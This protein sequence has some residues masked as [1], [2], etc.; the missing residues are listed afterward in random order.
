MFRRFCYFLIVLLTLMGVFAF[1]LVDGVVAEKELMGLFAEGGLLTIDFENGDWREWL[2]VWDEGTQSNVVDSKVAEGVLHLDDAKQAVLNFPIE[3]GMLVHYHFRVSGLPEEAGTLVMAEMMNRRGGVGL[4]GQ[5]LG[6]G[7]FRVFEEGKTLME[8]GLWGDEFV[9]GEEW[10]D[11]FFWLDPNGMRM[12]MWTFDP[13]N[14]DVI[15]G[16]SFELPNDWQGETWGLNFAR[17]YFMWEGTPYL[18]EIEIL[19]D[20]VV[21]SGMAPRDYLVSI[22]AGQVP[23]GEFLS[24]PAMAFGENDEGDK[25]TTEREGM[26]FPETAMPMQEY[27]IDEDDF[28][29]VPFDE[30]MSEPVYMLDLVFK[31][32]KKLFEEGAD[33]MRNNQGG[34]FG[35]VA[36]KRFVNEDEFLF[37][38]TYEPAFVALNKTLTDFYTLNSVKGRAIYLNFKASEVEELRFALV[39]ND[40]VEFGISFEE[41]MIPRLFVVGEEEVYPLMFGEEEPPTL[42]MEEWYHFVLG[43]D[44]MGHCRG[45]FWPMDDFL[46]DG[47]FLDWDLTAFENGERFLNQPWEFVMEFDEMS[48]VTLKEY[49][50]YAFENYAA[51]KEDEAFLHEDFVPNEGT[52]LAEMGIAPA[53]F[54]DELEKNEDGSFSV[55][56]FDSGEDANDDTPAFVWRIHPEVNDVIRSVVVTFDLFEV[57]RPTNRFGAVGYHENDNSIGFVGYERGFLMGLYNFDGMTKNVIAE[58]RSYQDHFGRLPHGGVQLDVEEIVAMFAE[59][60]EDEDR[61]WSIEEMLQLPSA[62][63]MNLNEYVERVGATVQIEIP[64]G[65]FSRY[66]P[67]LTL[68]FL[69]GARF[70]NLQ[71][72]LVVEDDFEGDDAALVEAV[73]AP[74]EVNEDLWICGEIVT[75]NDCQP[76]VSGLEAEIND[77]APWTNLFFDERVFDGANLAEKVM[78][79]DVD[80]GKTFRMPVA[81]FDLGELEDDV[82]G[83]FVLVPEALPRLLTVSRWYEAPGDG[84]LSDLHQNTLRFVFEMMRDEETGLI[85]GIWDFGSNQ[86]VAEE[87]TYANLPLLFFLQPVLSEE[88]FLAYAEAIFVNEFFEWQGRYYYAPG[89][90]TMEDGKAQFVLALDDFDFE[91][92]RF[93]DF[94][95]DVSLFDFFDLKMAADFYEGIGR[96]FGFYLNQMEDVKTHLPAERIEVWL[97]ADGKA[98]VRPESEVFRIGQDFF[99]SLWMGYEGMGDMFGFKFFSVNDLAYQCFLGESQAGDVGCVQSFGLKTEDG[100]ASLLEYVRVYRFTSGL[101]ADAQKMNLYMYDF[102]RMTNANERFAPAYDVF[103]GEMILEDGVGEKVMADDA[104]MFLSDWER[105]RMRFGTAFDLMSWMSIAG[106]F[107]DEELILQGLNATLISMRLLHEEFEQDFDGEDVTDIS[108]FATH[109]VR[110]TKDFYL[111]YE[112]TFGV[113]RMPAMETFAW[114]ESVKEYL[115]R[116]FYEVRRPMTEEEMRLFEEMVDIPAYYE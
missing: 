21:V 49:G 80:W 64:Y 65:V 46:H 99:T 105:M 36:E 93:Y 41:D 34:E 97:D 92:L 5:H 113:F 60:G 109:G 11:Y 66:R 16:A 104:W 63:G 10:Q 59:I 61:F 74:I 9:V 114:Q 47:A 30:L 1:G 29:P 79:M 3:T 32:T 103:S 115:T 77:Y 81:D 98:I 50:V 84:S 17:D 107:S 35:F 14:L 67:D 111:F 83:D 96:S 19:V 72:F 87:F 76:Y 48:A 6:G 54:A 108:F 13:N 55:K 7:Y 101:I 75:E 40:G 39:G 73:L 58:D 53:F 95:R 28:V 71:A 33:D 37:R 90:V 38:T 62:F 106:K 12:V 89:G 112:R 51:M 24:L 88:E 23:I 110:I 26:G 18:D 43:V 22:G 8:E 70:A 91:A 42:E 20:R 116:F 52:H 69:R 45:V 68:Q 27:V 2:E 94:M 85:H 25:M 57:G 78:L 102:L 44:E 100:F 82:E 4:Y 15:R 86:L 31:G 56:A